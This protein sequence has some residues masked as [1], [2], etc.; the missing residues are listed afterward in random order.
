MYIQAT[1]ILKKPIVAF[2]IK[3]TVGNINKIIVNPENGKVL[4][5]LVFRLF[6][7]P[8]LVL[9][10]DVL[11][12]SQNGI[13][14]NNEE[15]LIS[16][17]EVIRVD[18]LLRQRIEILNMKAKT[19]SGKYLGRVEDY[20]IDPQTSSIAKFYLKGSIFSSSL[21]LP[22]DKVVEIKKNTVIFSDDLIESQGATEAVGA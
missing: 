12:L 19:K 10:E 6:Q 17:I 13:L 22:M 11:E 20:L 7:K 14:I 8:K 1:Q 2:D 5:F 4:A 9:L 16:P 18:S 3:K 15:S 21:I